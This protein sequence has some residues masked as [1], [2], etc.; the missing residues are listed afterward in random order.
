M[1][2]R[3]TH[4]YCKQIIDDAENKRYASDSYL[5][6]DIAYKLALALDETTGYVDGKPT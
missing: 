6:I 1:G 2:H 5:W 4:Y 3:S